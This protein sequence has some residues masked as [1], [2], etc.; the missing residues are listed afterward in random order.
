MC[1]HHSSGLYLGDGWQFLFA[2]SITLFVREMWK[3]SSRKLLQGKDFT[4]NTALVK[5][6]GVWR[7]HA[8]G[9]AVPG[10]VT[11]RSPGLSLKS[12]HWGESRARLLPQLLLTHCRI[13]AVPLWFCMLCC[14][15]WQSSSHFTSNGRKKLQEKG[16]LDRQTEATLQ[17]L[18]GK[19]PLPGFLWHWKLLPF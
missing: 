5:C 11:N 12:S 8:P 9:K 4:A 6:S 1:F 16:G 19:P 13:P 17:F 3:F 15:P 2:N 7:C 14:I 10:L 18:Q